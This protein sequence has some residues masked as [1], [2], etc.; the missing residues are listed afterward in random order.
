MLRYRLVAMCEPGSPPSP[1]VTAVSERRNGISMSTA[2]HEV[3]VVVIGSGA[4]GLTAAIT[5]ALEGASALV[6]EKMPYYGGATAISGGSVWLPGNPVVTRAGAADSIAKGR[7]YLDALIGD[8]VPPAHKDAFL[9]AGP[10]MVA[11]LEQRTDWVRFQYS[12]GNPDCYPEL[13]GGSGEGRSMGPLML[14]ADALGEDLA[15]MAP[16]LAAMGYRGLIIT[17]ADFRDL[18]MVMRTSAGKRAAVRVAARTLRAKTLGARFGGGMQLSSGRALTGRLRLALRDLDVPLWLSAPML[19]LETEAGDDGERVVGVRTEHHGT[20][21][22][23]RARRGVV[24]ASG[25]FSHS[26]EM[27]DRFLASPSSAEWAMSPPGQA[28]DAIRLS[29]PLGAAIDRMDKVWGNP[30]AM[31]PAPD[32]VLRPSPLLAERSLPGVI[33]VDN[34]GHRYLN[35]AMPYVDFVERMYEHDGSGARAIPSWLVFDQRAKNRYVFFKTLPLQPFP[36]A[37]L[38]DG[39]VKRGATIDGL[40]S[41]IDVPA[42]QLTATLHRYNELAGAGHDDDFGKGD[43]LYDRYYGDPTLKNPCMHAIDKGPFYAVAVYP[44]ETGTRGGL[45]VDEHARVLRDDGTPIVGLYAAGNTAVSAIGGACTGPGQTIGAA[46]AYGWMAAKH[47]A[48][49]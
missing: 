1:R 42:E 26:D 4:G 3:D 22:T 17:A 19:G 2:T 24:L 14:E 15:Q 33:V 39:L 30:S 27:R 11:E 40:A 35:E 23:V 7:A 28:G 31:L 32:G 41:Q 37:W 6:L 45:V 43:S 29:S 36:K 5:T 47:L 13:P 12:R 48:G 38:K 49:A 10:K 8:D 25:G 46:M 9:A 44:A 21:V 16:P 34:R 18:N 20:E